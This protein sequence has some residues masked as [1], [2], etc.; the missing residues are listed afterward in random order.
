MDVGWQL[1]TGDKQWCAQ[2]EQL[3]QKNGHSG[4]R[5]RCCSRDLVLGEKPRRMYSL[6]T[7]LL[8]LSWKQQQLGYCWLGCGNLWDPR[9]SCAKQLAHCQI[10]S[11]LD[12]VAGSIAFAKHFH[13]SYWTCSQ[14]EQSY[15]VGP[16]VKHARAAL[17]KALVVL[18]FLPWTKE[19]I[20]V[21]LQAQCCSMTLPSSPGTLRTLTTLLG[22]GKPFD[23]MCGL[24]HSEWV[25]L[26]GQPE[27][28][29]CLMLP[30]VMRTLAK[31]QTREKSVRT[32]KER[33]MICDHHPQKHS[34]FE[35]C[36][37]CTHFY[38]YTW[39]REMVSHWFLLPNW[40]QLDLKS[41]WL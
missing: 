2:Y 33:T 25:G 4:G 30:A 34:L 17:C 26:P 7:I 20:L 9:V 35:A 6:L 16:G 38:F 39:A 18:L 21:L 40:A 8:I 41:K 10:W 24:C 23:S 22:V 5:S 27:C 28:R 13:T 31:S 3:F 19:Q 12:D 36:L 11:A 1:G 14:R 32:N 15:S 29:Y 37:V